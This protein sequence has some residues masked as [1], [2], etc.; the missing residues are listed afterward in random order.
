[1]TWEEIC[2]P[3]L[4][5]P[6]IPP[7]TAFKTTVM[8]GAS[9]YV[10][11]ST[12]MYASEFSSAFGLMSLDDPAVIAGLAVDGRPFFDDPSQAY[13]GQEPDAEGNHDGLL[14]TD[15]GPD[16]DTPMPLKRDAA[17]IQHPTIHQRPAT[18]SG[19]ISMPCS[20]AASIGTGN[21]STPSKDADTRE[22]RE[23]WKEYMRTP[24]S[25][26][27]DV[28]G[29]IFGPN[30]TNSK[31]PS[32]ATY[33]RQRVASMPSTKTPMVERDDLFA[34]HSPGFGYLPTHQP[35]PRGRENAAA[36]AQQGP[37]SSLRTTLHVKED[38]RS[39]EAAVM[40]RKAPTL[41]LQLRRPT[42][43]KNVNHQS[44]RGDARN[45][46]DGSSANPQMGYGSR[47]PNSSG[48]PQSS[49]MTNAYGE[50][51]NIILSFSGNE[52]SVSPSLSSSRDTPVDACSTSTSSDVGLRPS[53]KRL[54][55]Q[56][57]GPENSKRTFFGYNTDG[58]GD[59][60]KAG[61]S[62][63]VLEVK[64]FQQSEFDGGSNPGGVH[65]DRPVPS[66]AERRRRM[67][68]PSSS[69]E[70]VNLN[71]EAT[72]PASVCPLGYAPGGQGGGAG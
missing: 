10:V 25:G 8:V 64:R 2:T 32:P 66:I 22:L 13:N 62:T 21:S 58:V 15:V 67:S 53:F 11:T 36:V 56:T 19:T 43:A 52:E 46:K 35:D 20:F 51:D 60:D 37:T 14:T 42:K 47:P 55:S 44:S 70:K 69:V 61:W 18:S 48:F 50:G 45:M 57:L 59:R 39:Y 1:M 34:E 3:E 6:L 68:A 9:I 16:N 49:N 38:L 26:P 41:N 71:Q 17:H 31:N 63:K 7:N 30:M 24:L 72:H 4:L 40:A 65:P 54:A 5:H 33:R 12:L 29:N 28:A 27:Q 23:F